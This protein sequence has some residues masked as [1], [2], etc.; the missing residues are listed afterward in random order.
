M[1]E[2][3][4]TEKMIHGMALSKALKTTTYGRVLVP[5]TLNEKQ[6][7]VPRRKIMPQR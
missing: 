4:G 7:Y 1:K 2:D 6:L 3:E 5:K